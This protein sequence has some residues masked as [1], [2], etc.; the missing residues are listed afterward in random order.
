MKLILS[1]SAID[2]WHVELRAGGRLEIGG[3]LVAEYEGADTF[4]LAE[5]SRQSESGTYTRFVRDDVQARQFVADYLFKS[6]QDPRRCNYIG[7]W[8][9]HP[10]FP[11]RPSGEDV[12]SMFELARDPKVGIGFAILIILR[13]NAFRSLQ[14]SC[15][16]FRSDG[17]A[18][19]VHIQV[20]GEPRENW[21]TKLKKF[22]GL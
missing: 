4:R 19:P 17:T 7:E 5:F 1:A 11:V 18:E 6:K 13:L 10:L 9:T 16:C 21:L 15:T 22:I 14:M 12:K 2:R 8:H 20:D 3:I